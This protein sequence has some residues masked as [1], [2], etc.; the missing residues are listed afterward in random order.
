[1]GC[2]H[3]VAENKARE[4]KF[5]KLFSLKEFTDYVTTLWP[6]DKTLVTLYV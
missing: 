6:F 1:V 5:E 2:L 4:I 3:L